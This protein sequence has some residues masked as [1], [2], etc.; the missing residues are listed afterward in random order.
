MGLRS[1]ASPLFLRRIDDRIGRM[2]IVATDC[3]ASE[4]PARW[5]RSPVSC[6][7]EGGV[8]AACY[9]SDPGDRPR[10][11]EAIGRPAVKAIRLAI[12]SYQERSARMNEGAIRL[13]WP[14]LTV[15]EPVEP[16]EGART[17]G[18]G[19]GMTLLADLLEAREPPEEAVL[20]E[21][22]GLVSL[23]RER[24]G[25]RQVI[26]TRTIAYQG[27]TMEIP[28]THPIPPGRSLRVT[29]GA[30]VR[31]GAPLTDGWPG[32]GEVL[33]ILGERILAAWMLDQL[34][35]LFEAVGQHPPER[36]LA[37]LLRRML[38]Q[39]RI[40]QPGDTGLIPGT[41]IRRTSFFRINE[42]MIAEGG[43][44]AIA[45][46]AVVGISKLDREA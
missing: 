9:A 2:A 45:S 43:L 15:D 7:A 13:R 20:S 23:D 22:D 34:R 21:Q 37:L 35:S 41:L 24:H 42:R 25:K 26:V 27:Q 12:Q 5:P 18:L 44:P 32:P 36:H 8:C 14:S 6:E 19:E 33:R 30:Q 38:E 46:A 11:G 4:R 28:A 39:V 17:L 1:A 40:E 16:F 3:S 31:A 29:A 10:V